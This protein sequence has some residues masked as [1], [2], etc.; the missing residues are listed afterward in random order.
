MRK[1]VLLLLMLSMVLALCGCNG[2]KSEKEQSSKDKDSIVVGIQ[3]NLDSLDPHITAAAGTK[4]VLFNIFE[5]LVKPDKDG[6]LIPA[7]ASDYVVSEDGK[8]YTF[9]IRENVKFHNGSVVTA[10]DVKYSIERSAGMIE[11]EEVMEISAFK[12][13]ESV[14]VVD[15]SKVEVVLK[16]AD[17]ELISFMTVAIIPK[18]YD[19]QETKPVGTGPFK[20]VSNTFNKSFVMER[21]DEYWGTKAYLKTVT[22]KI[23]NQASTAVTELKSGAIDIYPYLSEDLASQL[24][25]NTYVVS[26]NTNLVQALFL[27]NMVEPFDDVNVRIALSYAVNKQGLIDMLSN[28][29]GSIIGSGLFPGFGKYYKDCSDVYAYNQEKAK[30]YLKKAGLEDG[31]KFTVRVPANYQYHMDS[32]LVIKDMLSKVNVNMEI[33]GIEWAT[34]LEDVYVGRNFEATIVGIDAKLAPKDMMVRYISDGGKNFINFASDEYDELYEKA[35]ATTNEEEKVE[36]YHQMQDILAK[37]AA[38][39][40]IQDPSLLVAIN[41]ELEGYTFYPVYVQDMSVVKFKD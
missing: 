1:K 17:T 3:N 5:G 36:Y 23:I 32:A 41:S 31:F 19:N 40:F 39:V 27:N 15:A 34:W 22:F 12:N 28:G 14:N 6:N 20:F 10:E 11:G 29:K 18:D 21:F 26:G 8:T 30:E 37:E 13:I 7:V 24:G 9:T 25:K 16:V 35:V 4:E 38:S 2:G 33:E